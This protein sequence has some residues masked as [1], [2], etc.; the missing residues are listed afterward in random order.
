MGSD[1]KCLESYKCL[2]GERRGMLDNG[3]GCK[4]GECQ[5]LENPKM[6]P[7]CHLAMTHI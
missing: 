1:M 2:T 3:E 7:L 5:Y 4:T 6:L